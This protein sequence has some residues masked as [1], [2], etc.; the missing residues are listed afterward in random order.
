MGSRHFFLT[1]LTTSGLGARQS[2][3][4]PESLVGQDRKKLKK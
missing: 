4:L 2:Y 1:A 3:T